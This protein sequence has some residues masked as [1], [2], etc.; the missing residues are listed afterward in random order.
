MLGKLIFLGCLVA[1]LLVS[2]RCKKQ[3]ASLPHLLRGTWKY[4]GYSGGFAGVSFTPVNVDG[5]YLKITPPGILVANQH[6][7][8]CMRFSFV[9]DSSSTQSRLIGTLNI[10]DTSYL[11]Q[12]PD[13]TMYSIMMTAD[14]LTIY[15]K[16]CADCYSF[17]FSPVADSFKDCP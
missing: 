4:V 17:T 6:D 10:S 7:S 9:E 16:L 14:A 2:G 15:P 13:E 3:E 5:P 8:K 12:M 1:L 11:L